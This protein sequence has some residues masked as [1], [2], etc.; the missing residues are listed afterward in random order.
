MIETLILGILI[1]I[2]GTGAGA[3]YAAN[4]Y[5]KQPYIRKSLSGGYEVIAID[6]KFQNDKYNYL[7]LRKE[8]KVVSAIRFDENGEFDAF[9]DIL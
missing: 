5:L 6:K 3:A 7:A 1:G 9:H 2:I 4:R 8:G